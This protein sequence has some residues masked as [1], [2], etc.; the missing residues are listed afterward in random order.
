MDNSILIA[1]YI[2]SILTEN[3]QVVSLLNN[4]TNKIFTF[5]KSDTLTF[6]FICHYRD[7]IIATYTKDMHWYNTVQ[8]TV[9]C[10]SSEYDVVLNLANAVR[11]ALETYRWKDQDIFIHPIQFVGIY[12]YPDDDAIVEE[13]HFQM[14]VE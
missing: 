9:K 4:N 3:E 12:E 14:M 2:Q 5:N 10:V 7:N 6:P 11:H 13:L 8:Y 1:K